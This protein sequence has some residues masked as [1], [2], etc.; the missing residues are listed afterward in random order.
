MSRESI[1][2][3]RL[4]PENLLWRGPRT[5]E[6]YRRRGPGIPLPC[7]ES[8]RGRHAPE[9]LAAPTLPGVAPR[10]LFRQD[11]DDFRVN[12]I[13][14]GDHVFAHRSFERQCRRAAM[15]R[16]LKRGNPDV[17]IDDDDHPLDRT[18]RRRGFSARTCLMSRGTSDSV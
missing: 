5:P 16:K 10:E 12:L 11:A 17:C 9:S 1:N 7:P 8:S 3:C 14:G 15:L 4:Q 2:P 13:A 6:T 18:L